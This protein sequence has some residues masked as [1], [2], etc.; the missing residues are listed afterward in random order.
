MKIAAVQMDVTIGD[1]EANLTR[2]IERLRETR[3]ADVSLTVF[4][5]CAVSGYCFDS[6]D[7]ARP[8]AQPI[9]GPA[10]DRISGAC[11]KLGGFAVFGMLE[12]DGERLYNAAVLVGPEGV[13][14]SYR[15]IHLPFLGVDRFTTLGNRPFAVHDVD[16]ARVGM[17]ICYDGAFPES[18]RVM[19]L[20]GADLIVLPTN[21]PPGS[22]CMAA[23]GVNMR[24]ME[25]AVYYMSVNRVGTERGFRFIG[26]SRICDP[27]G[28][29][30]AESTDEQ[31]AILY[32]DIDPA[33]ARQKRIIRVPD[34]HEIDR[35]ADRRPEMYSALVAQHRRARRVRE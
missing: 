12:A 28:D 32:A 1:V 22:E 21:W 18:A 7:E 27:S 29:T 10:T 14:G 3:S 24:A 33:K 19:T 16:G 30:L 2:I 31:P 35:L 26:R 17:H 20:E 4:A 5:E 23:Y 34:K 15:K 11:A 9:P 13:I 6:L 25:N 8:F